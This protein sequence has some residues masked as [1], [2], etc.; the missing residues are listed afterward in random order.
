M[1]CESNVSNVFPGGE[2]GLPVIGGKQEAVWEG[3]RGV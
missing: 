2:N 1:A 3:V